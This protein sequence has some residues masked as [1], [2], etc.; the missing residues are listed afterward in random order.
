MSKAHEALVAEPAR[1]RVGGKEYEVHKLGL[2][3]VVQLSAFA[4]QF[5][6]AAINKAKD[7]I[8]DGKVDAV[9]LA[10]A[11]GEAELPRL[12]QILL[13]APSLEDRDRL[14]RITMEEVSELIVAFTQVNDINRI[15]ANFQKADENIGGLKRILG[16]LSRPSSEK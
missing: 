14:E 9:I 10:E 5:G 1:I 8:T 16:S 2:K 13:N 6:Q 15:V 11:V 7:A 12:L 3:Q 4:A